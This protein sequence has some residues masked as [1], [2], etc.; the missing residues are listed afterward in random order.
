MGGRAIEGGQGESVNMIGRNK[1]GRQDQCCSC[2]QIKEFARGREVVKSLR[3]G[4]IVRR[5]CVD[6]AEIRR[7][8]EESDHRSIRKEDGIPVRIINGRWGED[9]VRA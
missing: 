8:R 1:L 7:R 4:S 3:S 5:A 9:L 6:I 2:G